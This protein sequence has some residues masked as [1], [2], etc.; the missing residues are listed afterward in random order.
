MKRF[1]CLALIII[2]LTGCSIKK[3]EEE[4]FDSIINTVLYSDTNL[5]NVSFEGFKF[6]L[7]RGTIVDLKKENN[8]EIKEG[9][10]SYYLYVDVVSYYYKTK[11]EHQ[12]DHKLFY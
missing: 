7:P 10:N 11:R 8:L 5:S 6:Y 1:I 12:I 4:S 2:L 9:N 3:V